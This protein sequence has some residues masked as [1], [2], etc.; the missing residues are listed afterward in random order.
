MATSE[1][2]ILTR[3]TSR[4]NA[5]SS[6][7]INRDRCLTEIQQPVRLAQNGSHQRSWQ[8]M[9]QKA[10]AGCSL[11]CQHTLEVFRAH[12]GIKLEPLRLFRLPNIYTQKVYRFKP[13]WPTDT[14]E[15]RRVTRRWLRWSFK[16]QSQFLLTWK[17]WGAYGR[18]D[19]WRLCC[20]MLLV[21]CLFEK[22]KCE[23]INLPRV[24]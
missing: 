17:G 3:T 11:D 5:S 21:S 6:R 9:Q 15:L 8:K 24:V 18:V 19:V 2:T 1:C 13:Q 16:L 12:I 23:K 7:V 14:Q 22:W 4:P 10:C 20:L